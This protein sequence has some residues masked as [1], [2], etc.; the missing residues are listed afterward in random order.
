MQLHNQLNEPEER[1]REWQDDTFNVTPQPQ[2]EL[3]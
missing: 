1:P 3:F 2:A